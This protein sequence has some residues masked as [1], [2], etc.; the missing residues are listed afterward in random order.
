[1]ASASLSHLRTLHQLFFYI[2]SRRSHGFTQI[3]F[4]FRNK[5]VSWRDVLL[6][7]MSYQLPYLPGSDNPATQVQYILTMVVFLKNYVD[8]IFHFNLYSIYR[9]KYLTC[10]FF[11]KSTKSIVLF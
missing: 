6:R 7:T 5:P 8:F 10:Q 9:M 4:R 3:I 1:M 11:V 2:I